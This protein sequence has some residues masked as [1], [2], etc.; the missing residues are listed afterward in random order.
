[1][2]KRFSDGM[3]KRIRREKAR[4]RKTAKTSEEAEGGIRTFLE[5]LNKDKKPA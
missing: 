3:R 5:E 2:P 1:M 4:I